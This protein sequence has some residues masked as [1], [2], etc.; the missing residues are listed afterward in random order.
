M[1]ILRFILLTQEPFVYP[2]KGFLFCFAHLSLSTLTSKFM[3]HPK[4]VKS[5]IVSSLVVPMEIEAGDIPV[6]RNRLLKDCSTQI[7]ICVWILPSFLTY[8]GLVA[9]FL[10]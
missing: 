9:Q 3:M 4:Y 8:E 6:E 10:E 1:S 2:T 5:W 7:Y